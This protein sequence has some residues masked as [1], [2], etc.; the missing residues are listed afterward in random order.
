M[1]GLAF[2]QIR[3][4][5]PAGFGAAGPLGDQV[6]H[7][8]ERDFGLMAPPVALHSPAPEVMAACWL[9]LR[10]TLLAPGLVGR[11]V[12][13]AVASAVSRANTCPYCVSVHSATLH[14]LADGR[15]A[16]QV[17][18]GQTDEIADP[19]LR[20]A[21]R[22]SL[23][24]P[25]RPAVGPAVAPFPPEQAPEYV[26]VALTFHYINRM[27]NV[28]LE[29][30]PMPPGA[31]RRGLGMVKRVLS[32]MIRS[33]GRR[34]NEPGDSLGLLPPAELPEDLRWAESNPYVARALACAAA[35]FERAGRRSVP[36]PVRELVLSELSDW[37]GRPLGAS[38][39]RVLRPVAA[40][41]EAMRPA[42]RLALL[43]ALAS[44]QVDASIVED[45]RKTHKDDA[46]LV[47]IAAWSAMAAARHVIAW[48]TSGL[49]RATGI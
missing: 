4:V 1:R 44:Y 5:T 23:D 30:A 37:D 34:V 38:R 42:G 8:I 39:S 17:R 14:G 13:E 24:G 11:T 36:E 15:V 45:C 12:K 32:T 26:G 25:V 27:V 41:P 48:T 19:L 10:E 7:Q 6:Y 33:A 18:E 16:K 35:A 46:S 21:V 29:D 31:P 43:A 47:E 22:W 28:F 40:L 49:P 3:Y 2:A 9:M 20:E